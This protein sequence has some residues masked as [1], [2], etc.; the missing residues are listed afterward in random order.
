M[1][2]ST[3]VVV[4]TNWKDTCDRDKKYPDLCSHITTM[5]SLALLS[6]IISVVALYTGYKSMVMMRGDLGF[7]DGGSS[8][9]RTMPLWSMASRVVQVSLEVGLILTAYQVI[10]VAPMS[11]DAFFPEGFEVSKGVLYCW[12]HMCVA[13][14]AF[15]AALCV[16]L[17]AHDHM[18]QPFH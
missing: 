10:V 15:A 14:A 1:L 13:V 2:N 18:N 12:M 4:C 6:L 9:L 8:L 11:H 3:Q 17:R 5:Q 7:G 16:F